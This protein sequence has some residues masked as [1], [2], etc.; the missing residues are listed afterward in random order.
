M[1]LVAHGLYEFAR[2]AGNDGY[3]RHHRRRYRLRN[4]ANRGWQ[5]L[6]FRL[7]SRLV[8][9]VGCLTIS[10]SNNKY[11]HVYLFYLIIYSHKSN[12]IRTQITYF[13]H[14]STAITQ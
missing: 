10:L 3:R 7:R 6:S 8:Y 2:G 12:S 13:I 1:E 11:I 5:V 4:G 14:L 9:V